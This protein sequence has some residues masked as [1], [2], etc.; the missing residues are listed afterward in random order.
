MKNISGY[1]KWQ[2]QGITR[3]ITVW[4]IVVVVLGVVAKIGGC[5]MPWPA[6][7]SMI[8]LV[9]IIG[10]AIYSWF[11]FS[12]QLYQLEQDRIVRELERK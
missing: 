7:I 12:Y 9:M 11:S 2:L 6:Q 5:P 1:I 4:G 10:D 3:S 8:G